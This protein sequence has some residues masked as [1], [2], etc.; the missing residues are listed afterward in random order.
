MGFT[1]RQREV[2][3]SITI[4]TGTLEKC[5]GCGEIRKAS[6]DVQVAIANALWRYSAGELADVFLSLTDVQTAVYAII[7][8]Y[9]LADCSCTRFIERPPRLLSP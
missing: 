8:D 3:L 7:G 5:S 6:G 9:P 2:A 4:A 1:E